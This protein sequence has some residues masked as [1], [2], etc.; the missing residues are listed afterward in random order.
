MFPK[1]TTKVRLLDT[2]ERYGNHQPD[3]NLTINYVSSPTKMWNKAQKLIH[4][5]KP[6]FLNSAIKVQR[7]ANEQ[8]LQYK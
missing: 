3:Q 1:I 2:N 6:V 8:P 5:A 7:D 4:F